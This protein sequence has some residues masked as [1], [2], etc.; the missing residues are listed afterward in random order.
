M[1]IRVFFKSIKFAFRAKKRV[2]P[3]MMVYAILFIVVSDGL[4]LPIDQMVW[5]LLMAF[6][7]SS[8]YAILISQF[9]RRDMSV[10]KCIGWS[11]NDVMLLVIGEVVL[12]TVA[13]FL[14]MLQISFEIMGIVAYFEGAAGIFD[15]VYSFIVI[16]AGSLFTTFFIVLGAQ[17]PGLFIAQRRAVS[18]PPMKALREE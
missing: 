9:R 14:I 13:S 15:A 5:Y 3:F 10:F 2:I 16:P 12:V 17:I 11:N 1:N 8:F 6:I 18:V 7:V 4:L